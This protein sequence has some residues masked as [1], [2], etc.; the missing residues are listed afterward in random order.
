MKRIGML[1]VLFAITFAPTSVA[2]DKENPAGSLPTTNVSATANPAAA[3]PIPTK[4]DVLAVYYWGM[5]GEDLIK[6]RTKVKAQG[7][8]LSAKDCSKPAG[9][10]TLKSK[11]HDSA[12]RTQRKLRQSLNR[13]NHSWNNVS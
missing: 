3:A 11:I 2:D 6:F 12:I 7:L 5:S 10:V 8:V 1:L 9:L 4:G 13:T